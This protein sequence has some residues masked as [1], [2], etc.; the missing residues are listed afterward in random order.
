MNY[1]VTQ[2]FVPT[3]V[4]ASSAHSAL[5]TQALGFY[6]SALT[7]NLGTLG[8][9]Y[10]AT[11]GMIV[12]QSGQSKFGTFKSGV[13]KKSNITALR[14]TVADSTVKQQIT[15][16]GFDEVNDG[17]VPT[18]SCG[19]EYVVTLKIQEYW[20]KGVYQPM[21][22]ESV[23]VNTTLCSECGGGCDSLNCYS[24]M[25][26]IVTKV[27]ANPLLSK[28]V[29]ASHVFKGSAPTYKYIL[30]I[31]D[32][33]TSVGG[34]KTITHTTSAAGVTAGTYTGVAVTGGTGSSA[35]F[36]VVVGGGGTVTS[37]A[38]NAAGSGYTIGDTLTIAGTAMTGGTSPLDDIVV[39]VVSTTGAEGLLL[40]DLKAYYPSATYGAIT[41]TAD[42]DGDPDT[43][44]T[45]NIMFEIVSPL[46]DIKQM[47]VYKGLA[48]EKVQVTAG[49]VTTCGVKLVGNTLDEFGNAC[50]PDAV[51]YVFN[52]VRFKVA[53]HPA[54]FTSQD[55]DL[56]DALSPW[57]ITTTQEIQ[58]AIGDGKALAEFERNHFTYN[59]PN[60]MEARYYWNPIYNEDVKFYVD[61][62]KT[63]NMYEL[64][65]IE[66]SSIGY[67]KKTENEHSLVVLIDST[68]SGAISAFETAVQAFSG[69]TL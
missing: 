8:S 48:W 59:L 47:P 30:T 21:I 42:T 24:F 33:G 16:L 44:S 39:T 7:T 18:F 6:N 55:F 27:N 67:E 64:N 13:I 15:Y 9:P 54:P 57:S 61:K 31:Q 41:I 51:P 19:E 46:V 56:E 37:V 45:G 22:Q 69:L 29:T 11:E 12:L 68:N 50:V 3:S 52:A 20:T 2:V 63:Y 66:A 23:R 34:V 43:N 36:N 53:V 49:S 62:T 60:V 65:Y 38:L 58:Y 4:N 10:V 5:A 26:E 1:K 40:D 14:K 32:P 28:Y 17:K 35:T 25:Q